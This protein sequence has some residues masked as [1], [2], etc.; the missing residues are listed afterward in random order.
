M[1][2]YTKNSFRKEGVFL[3]EAGENGR[4]GYSFFNIYYFYSHRR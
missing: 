1:L 2:R 3:I 4:L